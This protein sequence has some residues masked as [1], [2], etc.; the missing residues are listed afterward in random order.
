MW[1]KK[2]VFLI[3]ISNLIEVSY[4]FFKIIACFFTIFRDGPLE[5]VP[6]ID[7]Y[8]STQEQVSMS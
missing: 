1:N 7:D 2:T 3:I 4:V 8:I 6:F 5:G